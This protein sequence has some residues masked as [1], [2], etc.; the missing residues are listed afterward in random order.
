[1]KIPDKGYPLSRDEYVDRIH[2]A[3]RNG[4]I[5]IATHDVLIYH[6]TA[7]REQNERLREALRTVDEEIRSVGGR[8]NVPPSVLRD[9]AIRVQQAIREALG[10]EKK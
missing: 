3:C 7:L 4:S 10:E 5:G 8:K 6:D 1:M 2:D 9:S